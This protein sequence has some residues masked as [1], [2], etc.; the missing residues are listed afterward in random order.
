MSVCLDNLKNPLDKFSTFVELLCYRTQIQPEQKAYTFLVDGETE[1]ISL[2]YSELDQK[3]RAIAVVLHSLK[4]TGKRAILLYPPGLEF[5]TAFFGCLYAGVVA[6]PVPL[7]QRKERMTRLQAIMADADATFV[8]TT[9]SVFTNNIKRSLKEESELSA[10]YCIAT[11]S[12]T[13]DLASDWQAP[14]IS[15]NTLAFLQY[16]SGSTATPKGVMVSY[17]S[18]VGLKTSLCSE[19][20]ITTHKI[21]NLL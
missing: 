3:A 5:I 4:A 9:T 10:L 8:L 11:D 16:T 21:S 13:Y 7:V 2:T 1:E 20:V 18:R 19:V 12:I 14:K 15:S 17:S 6:V